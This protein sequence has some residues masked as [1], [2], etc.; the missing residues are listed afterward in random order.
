MFL[1]LLV[2]FAEGEAQAPAGGK[3]GGLDISFLLPMLAVLALMYFF[4]F[5]NRGGDQAS[6]DA[7]GLQ[8]ND[9]VLLFGVIIGQVVSV[10]ETL[11]EV[12]VKL[13][14]NLRVKFVRGAIH[15]NFSHEERQKAASETKEAP[16]ADAPAATGETIRKA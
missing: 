15:R 3:S 1:Q 6:K 7:L 11:D 14:E 12:V 9:K 8:K 16:K 13:D 4:F 5:R 2:L 10:H